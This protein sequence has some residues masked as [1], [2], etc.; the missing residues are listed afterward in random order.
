M[1]YKEVKKNAI[2][3]LLRFYKGRLKTLEKY[4]DIDINKEILDCINEIN[5]LKKELR[6]LEGDE[7]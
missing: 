2:N 7:H 4:R 3:K 5:K 6:E 1:K